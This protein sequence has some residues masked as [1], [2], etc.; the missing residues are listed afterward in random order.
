MRRPVTSWIALAAHVV[1]LLVVAFGTPCLDDCPD[2]GPDGRCPPACRTC[3]CSPKAGPTTVASVIETPAASTG[4]FAA[5]I[6]SAPVAPE[7]RDIFHVPKRLL[8]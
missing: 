4:S 8:A 7:P 5:T 2:D 3:P 1:F 6:V